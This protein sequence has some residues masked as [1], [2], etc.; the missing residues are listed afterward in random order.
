[1]GGQTPEF[2]PSGYVEDNCG[3]SSGDCEKEC[4]WRVD[5][6]GLVPA[7][8]S[9]TPENPTAPDQKSGHTTIIVVVAVVVLLAVAMAVVL[10]MR[11]KAIGP[12]ANRV[13]GGQEPI[14]PDKAAL[15]GSDDL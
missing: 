13:D 6:E 2:N 5:W 10:V 15:G 9:P 3:D 7:A 12:F 11:Q 1:M 4:Q 8:P 14:N